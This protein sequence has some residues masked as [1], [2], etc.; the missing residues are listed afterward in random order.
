M[1]MYHRGHSTAAEPVTQFLP[2]LSVRKGTGFPLTPPRWSASRAKEWFAAQPWRQGA[3]FLPSSASNQ[4]EMFQSD[5]FDEATISRELAWAAMLKYNAVRVFL[6]NL[7]YW[8]DSKGFL[9]RV[10]AF[11]RIA[12]SHGIGT[13]LV[14]FDGCWDPHPKNGTQLEP[15]P[16]V[17]NSRWAQAPGARILADPAT[18]DQLKGYVKAVVARYANDS[19]VLLFDVFNEP[20]NANSGSYS[21]ISYRVP[22]AEDAM[23]KELP[24]LQKAQGARSLIAKALQWSRE[25]GPTQPLTVGIYEAPSGDEEADLYR[26]ETSDWVLGVVDV[27]SVH[28]YGSIQGVATQIM[29]LKSL[30]RPVICS[31]YMS[32]NTGS[33]FDPV[34]GYF[35]CVTHCTNVPLRPLFI[36]HR[37]LRRSQGVWAFNW[38]LVAGRSQTNYPWDSWHIEYT[39]EPTLW[40]HDVLRLDGSP[41]DAAESAYLRNPTNK[42]LAQNILVACMLVGLLVASIFTSVACFWN[43]RSLFSAVP[44][45]ED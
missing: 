1:S 26:A 2:K 22:S 24:P 11:L 37:P 13:M 5:T 9:K 8:D 7:L 6:H 16:G 35:R 18:H 17:H 25:I 20:D 27:T 23:G 21:N 28:N 36:V 14:L 33:T 34:L 40:Q 29:D 32:R 41:Y 30:G 4:F 31:E 12:D 10:D 39:E 43:R 3:N 44:K 15:R 38:G 45:D 19:R 42:F